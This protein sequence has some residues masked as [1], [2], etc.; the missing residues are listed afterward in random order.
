M[1]RHEQQAEVTR[2]RPCGCGDTHAHADCGCR[3]PKS[4][5]GRIWYILTKEQKTPCG[6]PCVTFPGHILHKPDPC[7]YDQFLLMALHQ[8][9]TWD[10]PDVA[11]FLGGIEQYTY[12]L[13][14]GTTYT[15]AI[16]VHNSSRDKA[17]IGT[18][19][20]VRWIEFG[21]GGQTRHPIT[22]LT[23]DV[24]VWPGTAV[25]NAP[26]RTPDVPGHYCIEVELSHP[27]DGNPSNN[28]G[29]NN[30]QVHAAHSQVQ[31]PIR[32]FNRYPNGCPPIEEGGGP[33]LRPH[34][35]F[36]GWAMLGGLAGLLLW[37]YAPE[38]WPGLARAGATAAVGYLLLALIGLLAESAYAWIRRTRS[39]AAGAEKRNREQERRRLEPC[40]LVEIDVD[41]YRFADRIGKEFDPNQAFKG[42][43]AEWPARV[44][45]PRFLFADAE[46][47][48]DV[49]LIVDAPDDPGP[50]GVFNV[51]VRQ[52]GVP[53]GGVTIEITRGGA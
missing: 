43:A 13:T 10:N 30:T 32:I 14:A 21:A 40:N 45:P 12:D 39:R 9:V 5:L 51:N 34:R 50:A 27:D 7:I 16:T 1:E 29:W 38:P 48:R 8:P 11:I 36:L 52:G 3:R 20:A 4:T 44:E 15:L 23:A 17:A 33:V 31:R 2:K 24:P 19:V 42:R 35:V 37:R 28:R 46:A 18:S 49:L 41:S 47:Y 22:T 26:W 6:D 25:V 53:A